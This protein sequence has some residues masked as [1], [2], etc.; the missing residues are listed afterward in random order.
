MSRRIRPGRACR[1]AVFAMYSAAIDRARKTPM[2]HCRLD[3]P[4]K[5]ATMGVYRIAMTLFCLLAWLIAAHFLAVTYQK[6][7]LPD[8][9]AYGMF[10]SRRAWLWAH[11]CGGV[12]AMLLG[13]LQF[14]APLRT[15]WPRLH[16]WIGRTYLLGMAIGIVGA[17]GL[18][19]TSPAPAAIRIAFAATGIAWAVTATAGFIAIRGKRTQ[20]HRRWMI[21][22]YLVTLAPASFRLALMVP[23]LMAP[24]SP[25]LMIPLLLWLSWALPLLA[26]EAGRRVLSSSG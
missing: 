23:G 13:A 9:A 26:Y 10:W 11:L 24:A 3:L 12:L 18:I 5:S 25:L 8:A 7:A 6:Y 17:A 21:R 15:R 1:I 20:A 14:V 16:R 19:A 4:E 2:P 22:N